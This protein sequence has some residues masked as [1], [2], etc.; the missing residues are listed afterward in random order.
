MSYL[1][2]MRPV[3]AYAAH[4]GLADN[5]QATRGVDQPD[6][7]KHLEILL[8]QARS[9]RF[10]AP[11]AEFDQA[12]LA[13]CAWLDET[14][15]LDCAARYFPGVDTEAA[16]FDTLDS[17]LLANEENENAG[18]D[19]IPVYAAA[20]D[21]GFPGLDRRP[22]CL[23]RLEAHRLRRNRRT[24]KHEHAATSLPPPPA[25]RSRILAA[26]GT[27]VLW[28]VPVA[29]TILL[30]TVYRYLLVGLYADVVG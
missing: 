19:V 30:Y 14:L 4:L 6:V 18:A 9:R 22:H 29:A 27:A 8:A 15:G 16:F 20:L 23:A 28:A 10:D 3:F 1:D 7:R 11:H 12:W 13:L 26:A 21:L 24:A 5:G 25:S 2:D 17:L